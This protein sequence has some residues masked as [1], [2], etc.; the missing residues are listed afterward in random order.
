MSLRVRVQR[1]EKSGLPMDAAYRSLCEKAGGSLKGLVRPI[2]GP[3]S[4][5]KEFPT[6]VNTESGGNENR[7]MSV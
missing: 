7:Q 5:Y 6:G 4:P 1:L 3:I 2:D